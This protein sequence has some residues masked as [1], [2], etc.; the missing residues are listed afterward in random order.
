MDFTGLPPMER[1]KQEHDLMT[2]YTAF[3]EEWLN[4]ALA[5]AKQLQE[6]TP[7]R[8]TE[9]E[10]IIVLQVRRRLSMRKMATGS[11]TRTR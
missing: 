6:R 7:P 3:D 2:M 10:D 8:P 11:G 9:E 4:K 5:E 1:A